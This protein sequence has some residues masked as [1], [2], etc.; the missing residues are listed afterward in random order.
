MVVDLPTIEITAPESWKPLDEALSRLEDFDWVA[1]NSAN[2]VEAFMARPGAPHADAL[3][4]VAAVGEATSAALERHGRRADLLPRRS[5]ALAVAEE[6]GSGS[7]QRILIPRAAD[8][9]P[10]MSEALRDAGWE[11]VEV[12]AYRT[13]TASP[14]E[15]MKARVRD[16]SFDAVTFT[17]GSTVRGFVELVGLLDG[18]TP[19][20]SGPVVAC[21]G[22]RTAAVARD[23]GLRVDVVAGEQSARGLVDALGAWDD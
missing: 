18:L 9:P 8:V 15:V 19:G 11:V 2:A 10:T 20:G 3:P 22:P 13:I 1:F 16:G 6:L 5:E 23:A 4:Q 21:I 7:G 14:D 12:P 17:S